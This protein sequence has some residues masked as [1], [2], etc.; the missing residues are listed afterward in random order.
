M[1][2]KRLKKLLQSF[3]D[4]ETIAKLTPEVINGKTGIP[5]KVGKKIIKIAKT[6]KKSN[7][8]ES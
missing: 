2:K 8:I 4:P 7:N 6:R 5:L 1:G 3:D